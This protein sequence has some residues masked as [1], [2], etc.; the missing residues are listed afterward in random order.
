MHGSLMTHRFMC[1][2]SRNVH[3]RYG[4]GRSRKRTPGKQSQAAQKGKSWKAQGE[5]DQWTY[6]MKAVCQ[7]SEV[8]MKA[9]ARSE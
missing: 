5:Q 9:I 8:A 7:L 2:L 6:A 4:Q 1:H 3:A